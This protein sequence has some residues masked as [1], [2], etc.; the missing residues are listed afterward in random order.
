MP[1]TA[2]AQAEA[3]VVPTLSAG[4]AYD[5]NLFYDVDAPQLDA[6]WRISPGVTVIRQSPRT[7]F[8]TGYGF[9]AERYRDHPDLTESF[10]RQHGDLHLSAHPGATTTWVIDG[11]LETT[12]DPGELNLTTGLALGRRRAWRWGG[13]SELRWDFVP[14]WTWI[15]AYGYTEDRL[16]DTGTFPGGAGPL[17]LDVSNR[18]T[19]EARTGLEYRLTARHTMELDYEL[20]QFDADRQAHVARLG[21]TGRLTPTTR[22]HLAAGPRLGSVGRG[23]EAIVELEQA[24]QYLAVSLGYER[25]VTTSLGIPG[26]VAV[27]RVQGRIRYVRP[28]QI[29]LQVMGGAFRN[30]ANGAIA[31]VYHLG[32]ALT[33]PIK[34]PVALSVS[35]STDWQ[36]GQLGLPGFPIDVRRGIA[37]AEIVI[38]PT[39]RLVEPVPGD[40]EPEG[41]RRGPVQDPRLRRPGERPRAPM[42]RSDR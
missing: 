40:D 15:G 28:R 31:T 3:E 18:R 2:A 27:N 39:V 25:T 34:G 13:S 42:G 23:S 14:R 1:A 41:G 36:H 20:R 11:A 12:L 5:D 10:V 21:W 19:H 37:L 32:A 26:T 6:L 29:E 38:S 8:S 22:L 33:R 9:E 16:A 7:F 17:P 30:E 4:F 24:F 35:Y